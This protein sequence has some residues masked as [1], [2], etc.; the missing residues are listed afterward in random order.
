MRDLYHPAVALGVQILIGLLTGNFWLGAL[1][2]SAI[3]IGREHAQ[4]EYRWIERF[5]KRFE[6]EAEYAEW[7]W[8]TYGQFE[9]RNPG[10]SWDA[11]F[12]NYEDIRAEWD[13]LS[14]LRSKM[15]W[16]GGFDPKVWD[17]H[18]LLGFVLPLAASVVVAAVLS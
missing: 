10:T 15:P 18:S 4:A 17:R 7:H 13:K 6:N 12:W 16:W 9:G 11:Y 3:F 2:G 5:G 1:A 8:N 14:G